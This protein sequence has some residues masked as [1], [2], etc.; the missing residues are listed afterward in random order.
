VSE[1]A[2]DGAMAQ[3]VESREFLEIADDGFSPVASVEQKFIGKHQ[4]Q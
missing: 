4:W 3:Q 1:G 2:G